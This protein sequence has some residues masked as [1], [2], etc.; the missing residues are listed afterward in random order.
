MYHNSIGTHAQWQPI[1]QMK[2]TQW[3]LPIRKNERSSHYQLPMVLLEASL[4]CSMGWI[5]L[6]PYKFRARGAPQHY[7]GAGVR[8]PS[9][10]SRE[11]AIVEE[12]NPFDIL[13]LFVS[14]FTFLWLDA[15]Q[16]KCPWHGFHHLLITVKWT[17]SLPMCPICR[18]IVGFA[19]WL[20]VCL[21]HFVWEYAAHEV[22]GYRVDD[23][24]AS[25]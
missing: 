25:S 24:L 13:S 16:Y 5:E 11:A 17:L 15:V 19:S 1:H 8:I 12:W 3:S 21:F 6:Y 20:F 7:S 9:E 22:C 18:I 4:S 2:L 14:F 23:V 10:P